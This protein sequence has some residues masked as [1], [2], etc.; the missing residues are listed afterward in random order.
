M[1]MSEGLAAPMGEIPSVNGS[2]S[3]GSSGT[4]LHGV[5]SLVGMREWL[6]LLGHSVRIHIKASSFK[7]VIGGN[8]PGMY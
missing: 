3:P 6:C 1:G 8:R 5:P 7:P 2:L 4:I